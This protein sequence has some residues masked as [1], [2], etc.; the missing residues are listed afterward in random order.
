MT[1]K[2]IVEVETK[3]DA[4]TKECG[5]DDIRTMLAERLV[6]PGMAGLPWVI[7]YQVFSIHSIGGG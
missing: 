2:F 6:N 5:E 7:D 4:L 1:F 3:N